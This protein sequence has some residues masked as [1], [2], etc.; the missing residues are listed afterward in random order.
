MSDLLPLL[1]V[2]P[3]VDLTAID[4]SGTPGLPDHRKVR[5]DPKTWARA[6]LAEL[7]E[8]L[9][10][11]QEMLFANAKTNPGFEQRVLLVL[12]AMDC[13]G[14]DGTV[15]KVAGTMNPQ[16]LRIVA[17]G[18][19]TSQ[20][21][22]HDFLWR[23]R[24]ALP[25]PGLIGVFNRSHYEDVLV[26]RVNRLAPKKVWQARYQ[27]INEFEREL[28]ATGITMIKVMLHI[29]FEEQRKRLLARLDDPTK[30]WKYN[31]DDV[32][33]RA[34]WP[35]YQEAY[36]DALARCSTDLAPWYV[37]PADRKWYRDWAVAHLLLSTLTG[38]NLRYPRADYDV[39]RERERLEEGKTT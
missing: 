7:G 38:L 26:V 9:A 14:K 21:L 37:V 36:H 23:I 8:R 29:S 16:G 31:P 2:G 13:G 15:K 30:H 5:N 11:Q 17:F 20:E 24:N 39:A 35:A 33:N 1:R 28:T 18:P 19:P 6:D 12:Q 22:K 34:L 27:I 4:P 32:D 3:D 25:K 10:V